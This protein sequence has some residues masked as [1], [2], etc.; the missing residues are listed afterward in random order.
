VG[1][2]DRAVLEHLAEHLFSLERCRELVRD[3]VGEAGVVRRKADEQ[4]RAAAG[5]LADIDRRIA[6]WQ[7]AFETHVAS[8]DAVLPR[9][10]ELHAKRNEV[11]AEMSQAVSLH[12]PPPHLFQKPR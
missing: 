4:R 6:T 8:A 5:Q 9:L 7:E 12:Q 3:V 11:A 2:L 10:R 1:K